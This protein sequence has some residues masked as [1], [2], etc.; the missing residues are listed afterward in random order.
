[1]W[2]LIGFVLGGLTALIVSNL[3][4]IPPGGSSAV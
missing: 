1:M 3:P 2:F 4:P